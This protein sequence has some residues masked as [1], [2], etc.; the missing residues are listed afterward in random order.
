MIGA[1]QGLF[2][3]DGLKEVYRDLGKVDKNAETN[4][5]IKSVKV[6]DALETMVS[7][8]SSKFEQRYQRKLCQ[9]CLDELGVD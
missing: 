6:R 1:K 9:N 7:T 8:I 5:I 3:I 4:E 2:H